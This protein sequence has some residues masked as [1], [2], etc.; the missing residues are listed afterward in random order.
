MGAGPQ[1]REAAALAAIGATPKEI[2]ETLGVAAGT[3]T[4]WT[5]RADWQAELDRLVRQNQG[6]IL[7]RGAAHGAAA[8]EF[9][10]SIIDSDDP[11]V[12]WTQ[13]IGA[14]GKLIER[15][16]AVKVEQMLTAPADA[17]PLQIEARRVAPENQT[18]LLQIVAHI[19]EIEERRQSHSTARVE[20]GDEP[21]DDD[22]PEP[23]H[24]TIKGELAED[25]EPVAEPTTVPR[26]R[27]VPDPEMERDLVARGG[28]GKL[29]STAGHRIV[30]QR[31]PGLT[32]AENQPHGG[33]LPVRSDH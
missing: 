7:R 32:V 30:R 29:G 16:P 9:L 33:P 24:R 14:A 2:G 3:V 18:T 22:E 1:Q 31:E 13:K 28:I 26:R 15:M 12:S 19:R 27:K 17:A 6:L 25:D 8:L 11:T 23:D 21:E 4:T 20:Y 10:R 5:K